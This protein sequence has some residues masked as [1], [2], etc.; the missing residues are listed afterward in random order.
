MVLEVFPILAIRVW[1]N[2]G[3]HLTAARKHRKRDRERICLH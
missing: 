2:R 3:S 1:W